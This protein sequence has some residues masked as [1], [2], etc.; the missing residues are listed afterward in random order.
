MTTS[1]A[2]V[3][4]HCQRK[5]FCRTSWR[6]YINEKH[7][8]H[9]LRDAVHLSRAI[10]QWTY[11]CYILWCPAYALHFKQFIV[12]YRLAN[13]LSMCASCNNSES[14]FR[15]TGC[16]SCPSLGCDSLGHQLQLYIESPHKTKA[17]RIRDFKEDSL[18]VLIDNTTLTFLVRLQNSLFRFGS[19][20]VGL[21]NFARK[22]SVERVANFWWV[23]YST[24][25]TSDVAHVKIERIV[26]D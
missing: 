18:F 10:Q 16:F 25:L 12:L 11:H 19:L 6:A 3:R 13:L 2:S 7:C 4:S 1:A 24:V 23:Y 14:S 17:W 9:S 26:I 8:C 22:P 5:S 21:A 20:V 15:A